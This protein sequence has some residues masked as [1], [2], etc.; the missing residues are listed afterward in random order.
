MLLDEHHRWNVM[1]WFWGHSPGLP[2]NLGIFD[3]NLVGMGGQKA[4]W[5]MGSF[6]KQAKLGRLR[7]AMKSKFDPKLMWDGE[8]MVAGFIG[9]YR[10]CMAQ[11]TCG[12]TIVDGPMPPSAVWGEVWVAGA[13]PPCMR[14]GAM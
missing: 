12:G 1:I 6:V 3:G 10:T 8:G 14:V 2:S 4:W 9:A 5:R 13:F 7:R 11:G